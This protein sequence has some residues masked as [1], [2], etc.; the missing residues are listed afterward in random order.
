MFVERLD[1]KFNNIKITGTRK[2]K[3]IKGRVQCFLNT[4]CN[5]Q[6]FSPKYWKKL[7]QISLVVFKKNAKKRTL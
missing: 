7:A 2:V 6:V 1:S 4:G 3:Y 5:E